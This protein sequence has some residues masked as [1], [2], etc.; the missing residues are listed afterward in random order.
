MAKPISKL[1]LDALSSIVMI[2]N[3][4]EGDLVEVFGPFG[5]MWVH[6][7]PVP[8]RRRPAASVHRLYC[9]EHLLLVHHRKHRLSSCADKS[10]NAMQQMLAQGRI[11]EMVRSGELKVFGLRR[12]STK[13]WDQCPHCRWKE[14]N[15]ERLRQSYG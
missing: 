13:T 4:G 11:E 5:A 8:A 1:P 9:C 10:M 15:L 6:T 7:D 14:R 12:P 2:T 3:M